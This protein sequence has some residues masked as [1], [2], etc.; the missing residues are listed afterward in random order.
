MSLLLPY[1]IF[2]RK[3]EGIP[4]SASSADLSETASLPLVIKEKD[5]EYQVNVRFLVNVLKFGTF[6]SVCSQNNSWFPG[7]E[8]TKWLSA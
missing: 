3:S 2:F 7:M 8:F 5:V 6:F 4:T 1:C